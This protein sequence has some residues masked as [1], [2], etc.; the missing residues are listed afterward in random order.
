MAILHRLSARTVSAEDSDEEAWNYSPNGIVARMGR[1]VSKSD[2]EDE[3][4]YA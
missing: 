4:D 2:S 3:Q 1:M